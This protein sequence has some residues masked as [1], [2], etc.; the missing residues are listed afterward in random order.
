MRALLAL[1]VVLLASSA[2]AQDQGP[3][4][5]GTRLTRAKAQSA[6][7]T[8]RADQLDRAAAAQ[9][10][11]ARQAQLAEAALAARVSAAQADITAAQ[12]RGALVG[13]LA[14]DQRARLAQ[15][16]SPIARLLAALQSLANRPPL[17]AVAQPGTVDDLVHV[18]AVLG[19]TIPAI[20]ARTAEAR[21]EL[22]RTR[23]LQRSAA[24]AATALRDGRARLEANRL[25]LV[26]LEAEH[27]LRAETLGRGA[28][29]QSDRALALGERARDIVGVLAATRDA[30]EIEASLATLPGPLPRPGGTETPAA[31]RPAYRLPAAGRIVVGFGEISDTGVRSRGLTLATAPLAAVVAPASGRIAYVGHFRGYGQV[32]VIDHGAGWASTLTGLGE[33][34]VRR[35]DRVAAGAQIGRAPAEDPHVTAELRRRGRPIEPAALIG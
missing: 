30:A 32:V 21:A 26:K 2:V 27:R 17:V 13:R 22:E 9:T 19:S 12:A 20:R 34:K 31:A 16:Q 7:A 35:G 15:S 8:T 6:A 24:L 11:A 5:L 29:Y 4:D 10:D 25:A 14:A 1:S 28:L 3:D 23:A 33:T 18:R